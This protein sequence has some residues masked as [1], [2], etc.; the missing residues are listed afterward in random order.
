MTTQAKV[1]KKNDLERLH[2][3]HNCR[4]LTIPGPSRVRCFWA[5]FRTI[6]EVSLLSCKNTPNQKVN[7]SSICRSELAPLDG[8]RVFS[9]ATV[10]KTA[11]AVFPWSAHGEPGSHT[12]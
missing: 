6:T 11:L 10:H 5:I 4:T 2:K 12:Q 8:A 9:L 1:I 7:F 3:K